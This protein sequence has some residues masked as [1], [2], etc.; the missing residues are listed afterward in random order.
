MNQSF[1]SFDTLYMSIKELKEVTS[2]VRDNLKLYD[3]SLQQ[4]TEI[5][6]ILNDIGFVSSVTKEEAG[7]NYY[8]EEAKRVFE[9]CQATLFAK[10]GGMVPLL[11]LFYLYNKK[12]QTCLIAPE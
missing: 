9:I 4:K 11:D 8:K 1:S 6:N 12:R 2:Y 10:F 5:E 7:K 3:E